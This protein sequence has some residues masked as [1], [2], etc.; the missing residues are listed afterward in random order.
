MMSAKFVEEELC[1]IDVSV[2]GLGGL[3]GDQGHADGGSQVVDRIDIVAGFLHTGGF[4]EVG[5]D[6]TEVGIGFEVFEV[7]TAPGAEI[8]DHDDMIASLKKMLGK[9]RADEAATA[10]N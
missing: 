7:P 6:D 4:A 3:L 8:V 10:G 9:V 1:G 2:N 5:A